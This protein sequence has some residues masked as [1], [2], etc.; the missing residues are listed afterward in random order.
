M[1]LLYC[2]V[3]DFNYEPKPMMVILVVG[4]QS[5]SVLVLNESTM[6]NKYEITLNLSYHVQVKILKLLVR[7]TM[8]FLKLTRNN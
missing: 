7:R 8:T 2:T 3:L 5:G 6:K 1:K 4:S